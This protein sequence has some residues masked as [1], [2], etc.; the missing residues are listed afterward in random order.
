MRPV[1]AD[2][3]KVTLD[4]DTEVTATVLVVLLRVATQTGVEERVVEKFTVTLVA[5][6]L[7][8]TLNARSL[9]VMLAHPDPQ[10]GGVPRSL[11]G[12]LIST[13][14]VQSVLSPKRAQPACTMCEAPP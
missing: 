6:A 2:S 13:P 11:S 7:V 5:G 1:F 12:A 4:V 8:V 10:L 3:P 14:L 9:P